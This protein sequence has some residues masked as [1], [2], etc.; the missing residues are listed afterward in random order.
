MSLF[1]KVNIRICNYHLNEDLNLKRHNIY[2]FC[3]FVQTES[4]GFFM[5]EVFG[6]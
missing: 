6:N 1:L 2:I 3:S 5:K 4:M